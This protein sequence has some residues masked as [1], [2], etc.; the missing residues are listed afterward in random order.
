METQSHVFQLYDKLLQFPLFQGLGYNDLTQIV[1]HTK[2]D[3][4][5]FNP[6][7]TI[8]CK[9]TVCDRLYMLTDG[10]IEMTTVADHEEYAV[11][12]WTEAPA[13][14]QLERLFGLHQ[15]FTNQYTATSP[16]SFITI[17]KH[18]LMRLTETFVVFRMNLMNV[19]TTHIQKFHDQQWATAPLSLDDR[20]KRFFTSHCLIPFGAKRFDILMK[21]LSNEMNDSRLDTSQALN[22]LQ[23]L[24]LL[25]L[26][27]G[28]IEIPKIECL[29]T[30]TGKADTQSET[31]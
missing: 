20:I 30:P 18:E 27:R 1:A 7:E 23:H 31:A 5:K 12:E 24:G 3:F 28:R 22:R 29:A 14:F 2:F 6:G 13:T 9:G 17:D 19:L 8:V 16:C 26:S 11:H 21:R 15:Q 4:L 10:L 25:T